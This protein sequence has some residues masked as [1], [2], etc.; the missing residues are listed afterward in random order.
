MVT[1]MNRLVAFGFIALVGAASSGAA[2]AGGKVKIEEKFDPRTGRY[3]YEEK[4]P[5]YSY[6]YSRG[7]NGSHVEYRTRGGPPPWAPAH[8]QRKKKGGQQVT[9]LPPHGIDRGTC[10]RSQVG[11]LLGAAVGGAAGGFAGS[12]IGKGKGQL[13]A[14]AAGAVLGVLVGGSIG[15]A[16]DNVDQACVGQALEHAPDGR[17]VAWMERPGG[18]QYQMVPVKSYQT[19]SGAYCREY[20]TTATIGGEAQQ[21][22]GTACRQPDGQWKLM[23]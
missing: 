22:Y 10:N 21:T 9:Y 18:P 4:G 6:E 20:Q 17:R 19:Q 1:A 8:G 3:T 5:G 7:G 14:T 16:M 11:T 23:N 2:I 15:N 13:A 12:Q